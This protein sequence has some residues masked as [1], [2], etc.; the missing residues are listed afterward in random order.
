MTSSLLQSITKLTHYL[1]QVRLWQALS[2]VQPSIHLS[3]A[4]KELAEERIL[5]EEL[6]QA[7]GEQQNLMDNLTRVSTVGV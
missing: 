3:Q 6:L 4:R 2:C 5:R 7:M 1:N